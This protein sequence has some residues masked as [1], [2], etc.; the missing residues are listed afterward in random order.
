M[1]NAFKIKFR[2][3]NV[4]TVLFIIYNYGG[5][6]SSKCYLSSILC[7]SK[8]SR[9][10]GKDALKYLKRPDNLTLL[11]H[12][13]PKIAQVSQFL[14]KSSDSQLKSFV[15]HPKHTSELTPRPIRYFYFFLQGQIRVIQF[16][17]FIIFSNYRYL[18]DLHLI[19]DWFCSLIN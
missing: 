10:F 11:L 18:S 1:A 16:W 12:V 2:Y 19:Y 8:L 3:L 13:S 6:S 14:V 5:D 9:I 7:K 17:H 15:F 4:A